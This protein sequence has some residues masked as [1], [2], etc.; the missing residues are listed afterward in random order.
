[1]ARRACLGLLLLLAAAGL[2]AQTIDATGWDAGTISITDGWR[3]HAGDN[4][5]WAAATYD[6]SAWKTVEIDDI[7]AAQPGWR[8]FRLHIHL[9]PDHPSI[10]LFF[11]GGQGAYELYV[12]GVLQDGARIRSV[13]AVERPTEQVLFIGQGQTDLVLALRSRTQWVYPLGH[14]PLFL[15]ASLGTA[16]A[17]DNERAAAQSRRLYALL[18]TLAINLAVMLAGI[19][20]L[21]LFFG[22]RTHVEY[23]WLGLYLVLLAFSNLLWE[24]AACGTLPLVWN[25][26]LGDPLIYVFTVMQIE[27]TFSFAGRHIGRLWRLYELILLSGLILATLAAFGT[28]EA[29][30]YFLIEALLVL[31]AA[32][33][34]PLLLLIWYRGGN[35]EAGWLILPSL[36]PAAITST[37]DIGSVS[38]YTGWGKLDF[39]DNPIPVGPVP[40]GFEDLGNLLFM[41]AVGVVVFFRFTRVSRDQARSAA[42][43]DAG[44]EI[45]RR[46]VPVT[47]PQVPG[48]SL[49]AAYLPAAEVGGDFYQILGQSDGSTIVVVGDVSGKG[50]QAAM[51]GTLALGAL[52]T[53]AAEGLG[54]GVLLT[55]LNE[56]IVF[57]QE[58]GFITCVCVRIEPDGRARAANAGHLIP[59]RNGEEIEI[60][61]G[62]PLGVAPESTYAEATFTIA[63]GDMLTL[64]S[65]GVVEAMGSDGELFGFARTAAISTRPAAEIARAAQHFGQKDDITVLTLTLIAAGVVH[66]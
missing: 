59:Y 47:L 39:L 40:I 37:Y 33:L 62:L 4:L 7:G 11:A 45:Q 10:Y 1:M 42:E 55:R 26:V 32:L 51:T 18:P 21:S 50:L 56:Q 28:L 53:L 44:R 9:A 23:R 49:E 35:R 46:M 20:C 36:L 19:G 57:T 22:Q 63:P 66:A 48:Y 65:D 60:E 17:V 30:T 43:L 41:L 12:N 29:S 3:T 58:E 38:I 52:R 31:P 54:P 14:L 64:L 6:D 61:S 8:W 13:L 5:T 15:N 2:R 25:D 27:F 24:T 16:L 34:L